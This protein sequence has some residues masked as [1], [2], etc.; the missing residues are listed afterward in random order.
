MAEQTSAKRVFTGRKIIYTD[1]DEINESNIVEV[2]SDAYKVH[3]GNAYDIEYLYKYYKGNQDINLRKKDVRPEICNKI[4]DNYAHFIVNFR[5][6]HFL[7][8]DIQY[9]CRNGENKDD[10]VDD[11]IKLNNFVNV[12][13]KTTSD[14]ELVKWMFL[15]GTGYRIILNSNSDDEEYPFDAYTLD[16]RST[17]VV[18]S[19]SIREEPVMGVKIIETSKNGLT[20]KRFCCYTKNKYFEV[21]DDK[22]VKNTGHILGGIPIVEY[23]IE[24]ARIG[25]I[26]LVKDLLDLKNS[27]LSNRIDSV[28]QFVQALL[29]FKGFK[30]DSEDLEKIKVQS[31]ISTPDPQNDVDYITA[32]LNQDQIQS[33]ANYVDDCI[34]KICGIPTRTD[35]ST[36]DSSNNKAV[37]LSYGW[38]DSETDAEVIEKY[39]IKS[40]MQALN[41]IINIANA[42]AHTNLKLSDIEIKIPRT[43][44]DNML[45]KSQFFTT[46]IGSG[47]VA[48]EA[49]YRICKIFPDPDLAYSQAVKFIKE[50][51]DKQAEQ[52][53]QFNLSEINSA[54]NELNNAVDGEE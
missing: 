18:Y 24:K 35:G 6:G 13:G 36:S 20:E 11:V 42:T 22:I 43:N 48:P 52:L 27:L 19:N 15:C 32:E 53:E 54:K 9:V 34:N 7:S 51:E 12:A 5:S 40:E 17:F 16:P 41:I 45:E 29:V 26:E 10:A 38:A 1:Y 33:L 25:I 4:V 8:E 44:Y 21:V 46:M 23:P 30:L 39:F 31:G 37:V 47:W 2:L 14:V 28:E 3:S 50:Q 49:I